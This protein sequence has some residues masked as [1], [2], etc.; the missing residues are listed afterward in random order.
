[1]TRPGRPQVVKYLQRCQGLM[2]RTR[3]GRGQERKSLQARE[4]TWLIHSGIA[5][6]GP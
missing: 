3:R 2:A 4:I 6:G 1:M 5:D